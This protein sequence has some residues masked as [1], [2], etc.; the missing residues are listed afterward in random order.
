[1]DLLTDR[2]IRAAKP[3]R[4]PYVLWDGLGLYLATLP[5]GTRSWRFSWR[6]G[7]RRRVLT[8]GL[9]PKLSLT[10]AREERDALRQAIREGRDPGA[11]RQARRMAVTT[12]Q[13]VEA[14]GRDWYALNVAMWRPGYAK[15]TLRI[16]EDEIFPTLGSRHVND[17]TVP[18]VLGLIRSIESRGAV[19]TASRVRQRLFAIFKHAIGCGIG[20]NNPA[21]SIPLKQQ[22]TRQQ[23]AIID[24]NELRAM[25][26][27]LEAVVCYPVSKLALRFLALTATRPSEVQFAGWD[28]FEDLEGP[29]PIW[30]I[31]SAR[32]KTKR[33]F[34]VALSTA[35]VDVLRAA[36]IWCHNSRF[37]FTHKSDPERPISHATLSYLLRDAGYQ[38]RHVPHGFRSA[39]STIMTERHP[40]DYEPIE[41]ALAHVVGGT[42]GRYLRTS[43][44]DR[45]RKLMEEWANLIL[46]G[47]PDAEALLLG[48]RKLH[49]STNVIVLS[50]R[51]RPAA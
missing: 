15:A 38:D 12:G 3:A 5:T 24:L 7:S 11:E 43:F 28:E 27:S 14:M 13:S 42:R 39:F 44:L 31:P 21:A 23:P 10:K 16:L 48:Q 4:R 51:R 8:L 18:A 47:A 20:Q 46:D 49:R 17:V 29:A 32:M 9:Y 37:V 26:R 6:S 25:L 19:R 2:K 50:K 34:I 1:V 36:K 35:A 40:E 22:P 30:R 41:A 33:E 45:R